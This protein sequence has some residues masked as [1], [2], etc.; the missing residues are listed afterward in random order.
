MKEIGERTKQR[1]GI[2]KILLRSFCAVILLAVLFHFVD[3]SEVRLA[4]FAARWEYIAGATLLV[5]VNIGFQIL[6]WRYS[7][8]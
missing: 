5:V 2:L 4:L 7:F 6:K 1:K 3:L 8:A